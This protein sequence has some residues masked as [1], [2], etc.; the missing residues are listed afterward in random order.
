MGAV[1][2]HFL[3]W[4]LLAVSFCIPKAPKTTNTTMN[5]RLKKQGFFLLIAGYSPSE[6][7]L[8]R[9]T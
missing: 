9:L 2:L 7:E 4:V 6:Y 3:I 8:F 5:K 1:G